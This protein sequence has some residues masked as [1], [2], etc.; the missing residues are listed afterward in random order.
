[1]KNYSDKLPRKIQSKHHTC[2]HL[3]SAGENCNRV[4]Q[5]EITVS[6][7]GEAYDWQD[8]FEWLR[9]YVCEGHLPSYERGKLKS[10]GVVS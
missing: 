8:G 3:T 7:D 2:Q 9:L 4:G 10:K 1:M 5:Y 6:I